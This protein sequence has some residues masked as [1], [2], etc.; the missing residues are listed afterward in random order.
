[1]CSTILEFNSRCCDERFC[2]TSVS[3][4][5]L[6]LVK[7]NLFQQA[8]KKEKEKKKAVHLLP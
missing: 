1:M 7:R 2:M 4:A 8:V 5:S 6:A 3:E